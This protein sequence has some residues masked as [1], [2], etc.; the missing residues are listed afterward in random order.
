MLYEVI[1]NETG[2]QAGRYLY[3]THELRSPDNQPEGGSVSV[4]DLQTGVARLLV[5]DPTYNRNNFV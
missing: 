4:V 5:Q 2:K 1:T 3:R